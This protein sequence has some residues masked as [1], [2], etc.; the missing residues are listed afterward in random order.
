MVGLFLYMYI[1]SK[2]RIAAH[3]KED[4][5]TMTWTMGDQL[6]PDQQ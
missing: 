6:P 3:L 1:V 2:K 4:E 5:A